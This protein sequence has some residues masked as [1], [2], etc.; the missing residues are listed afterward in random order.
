MLM[1][2]ERVNVVEGVVQDLARAKIPN[3]PTEK[4]I[5]SEWKHNKPGLAK[6]IAVTAALGAVAFALFRWAGSRD[7]D[8]ADS[9]D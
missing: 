3:I 6:K 1:G 7:Y 5:R 4:G 8:G 2:A 9:R